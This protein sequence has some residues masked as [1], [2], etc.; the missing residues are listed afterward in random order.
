MAQTLGW[1]MESLK[2]LA[3]RQKRRPLS[4]Q[5]EYL[6]EA[7]LCIHPI[8]LTITDQL[9]PAII[10]N[11]GSPSIPAEIDGRT[12]AKSFTSAEIDVPPLNCA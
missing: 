9:R 12:T 3:K 4:S 6:I 8:P 7:L 5:E 2:L 10:I 1:M 11:A